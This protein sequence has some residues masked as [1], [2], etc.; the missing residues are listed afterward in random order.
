MTEEEVA[1][2]LGHNSRDLDNLRIDPAVA[3]A[4]GALKI[5]A[6][7]ADLMKRELTDRVQQTSTEVVAASLAYAVSPLKRDLMKQDFLDN[8]NA[9]R[10]PPPPPPAIMAERGW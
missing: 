9:A 1:R 3:A 4:P 6:E 7:K 8:V 2:S 10:T 5:S